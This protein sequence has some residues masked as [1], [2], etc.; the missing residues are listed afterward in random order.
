MTGNRAAFSELDQSI[1]GTVKFGDGSVVDIVCRGTILFAARHGRTECSP[2]RTS[3]PAS[4]AT[5]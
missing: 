1:M 5:S 4:E 2:T 3:Y